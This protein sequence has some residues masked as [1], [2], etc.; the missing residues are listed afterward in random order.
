[1][2][3]VV[4]LTTGGTIASTENEDGKLVAGQLT[5]KEL[6][7]I[8]G[9]PEDIDVTTVSMLQKPSA[10]ITTD[11]WFMLYEKIVRVFFGS[12]SEWNRCYA[13]NRYIRG[14]GLFSRFG[15]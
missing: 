8:C 10:H 15:H 13:W 14:D 9:L 11:D 1:M 3:R 12:G 6:T 7:E 2:R 4:L 5:G